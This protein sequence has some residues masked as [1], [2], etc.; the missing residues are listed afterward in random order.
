MKLQ[1]NADFNG[2]E[3]SSSS[4]IAPSVNRESVVVNPNDLQFQLHC[5]AGTSGRFEIGAKSVSLRIGQRI[6]QEKSERIWDSVVIQC[7]QDEDGSLVV[8]I[9]VCNPAWDEPLQIASLVS[10]ALA[11]GSESSL[12]IFDLSHKS[13]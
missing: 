1:G 7:K 10:R 5:E 11:S 4:E 8:K 13:E 3:N 2:V 12:I 6:V 9:D